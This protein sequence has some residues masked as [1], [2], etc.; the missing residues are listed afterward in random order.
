MLR[1]LHTIRFHLLLLLFNYGK[2]GKR[3]N[4]KKK[5]LRNDHR[6]H[7]CH[8]HIIVSRHRTLLARSLA[9]LLQNRKKNQCHQTV[10]A[11]HHRSNKQNRY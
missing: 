2:H 5:T 4:L 6:P 10:Y 7:A 9:L 8:H 3:N 1:C 11:I